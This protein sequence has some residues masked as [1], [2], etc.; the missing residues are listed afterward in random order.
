MTSGRYWLCRPLNP[1]GA[2]RSSWKSA[3][4]SAL[5]LIWGMTRGEQRLACLESSIWNVKAL[6]CSG[7]SNVLEPADEFTAPSFKLTETAVLK[8]YGS[9]GEAQTQFF[10]D[11]I[12]AEI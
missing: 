5:R 4:W 1:Y 12:P 10:R 11:K 3:V 8:T 6:A 9:F 2:D 7:A